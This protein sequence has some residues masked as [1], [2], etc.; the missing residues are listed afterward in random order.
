MTE[1]SLPSY[2]SWQFKLTTYQ[3]ISALRYWK[4]EDSKLLQNSQQ[5]LALCNTPTVSLHL[6]AAGAKIGGIHYTRG[7]GYLFP[8]TAHSH[9]GIWVPIYYMVAS[10]MWIWPPPQ[11][12]L[13][14]LNHF[15]KANGCDQHTDRSCHAICSYSLHQ[16]YA[17][18]VGG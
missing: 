9:S 8:K 12:A 14:R 4:Y 3:A 17:R 2:C 1:I 11:I 6:M 18:N 13:W 16:C 15:C 7:I 10:I 5:Q